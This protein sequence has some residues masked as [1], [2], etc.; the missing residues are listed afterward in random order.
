MNI[1]LTFAVDR[2]LCRF[3]N[4]S[5]SWLP[6]ICVAYTGNWKIHVHIL[7]TPNLEKC[8]TSVGR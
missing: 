1:L 6:T 5:I 7:L 3:F 4:K 8:F 2:L